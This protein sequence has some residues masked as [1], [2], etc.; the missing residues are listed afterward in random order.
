MPAAEVSIEA[1]DEVSRDLRRYVEE[2]RLVRRVFIEAS[3]ALL[4]FLEDVI[5]ARRRALQQAQAALHQA[6]EVQRAYQPDDSLHTRYFDNGELN[7]AVTTAEGSLDRALRVREEV[8]LQ[9][10]NCRTAILA[11]ENATSQVSDRAQT[12]LRQKREELS[13]YMTGTTQIAQ[14]SGTG[15]ANTSAVSL[16][17]DRKGPEANETLGTTVPGLPAN[18][19]MVPLSAID[20]SDS[21]IV[22]AS[23]FGKGYSPQ[24]LRWAHNAFIDVVLPTLSHGG[25]IDEL[26][27]RDAAEG[28]A[29]V[30][31][32][33]DTYSGFLGDSA[34]R[35]NGDM[36]VSNGYH[37]IWVAKRMGLD[38]VPVRIR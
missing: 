12:M 3:E 6:E 37:R 38:S 36:T 27:A 22:D 32:Y 16:A 7:R 20:D 30:R 23:D 34:I 11:N 4:A 2:A 9:L 31:S 28:R 25:S 17:P 26:R 29:G 35:I 18:F 21:K 13:A 1:V 15:M 10:Q 24:D 33:A 5:R 8:R 14:S 19:M